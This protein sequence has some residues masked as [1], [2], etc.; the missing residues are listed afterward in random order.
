MAKYHDP[1]AGSLHIL[2]LSAVMIFDCPGLS[3]VAKDAVLVL[4]PAMRPPAIRRWW[5]TSFDSQLLNRMDQ[6]RLLDIWN[7]RSQ[8]HVHFYP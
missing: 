4:T 3:R 1:F 8:S 2:V 7:R 6:V 5:M